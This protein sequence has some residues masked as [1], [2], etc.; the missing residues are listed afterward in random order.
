MAR[1]DRKGAMAAS[2]CIAGPADSL[3]TNLQAKPAHIH[4]MLDEPCPTE[5]LLAVYSPCDI[6]SSL[7]PNYQA[8]I[9][10]I[11]AVCFIRIRGMAVSFMTTHMGR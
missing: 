3:A 2:M 10:N 4:Q 1:H 11:S 8:P 9:M 7:T 6:P 5:A